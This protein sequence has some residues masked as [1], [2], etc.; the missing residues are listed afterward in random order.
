MK[1]VPEAATA[2]FVGT[3][4]DSLTGRGGKDGTPLRQTPWGEIAFQLGGAEAFAVVAEHDAE[5]IAPAGDVI[6]QFLPKDR[7]AL[8]LMDE[9]H[10]L[11]E[12]EPEDRP[13]DAALQLPPEPLGG[14][15]RR[16]TTW[17]WPCRSRRVAD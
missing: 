1:A 11:R 14:G 15:A 17:C 12:P 2:V 7:P 3:E 4:F 8:I 13:D 5:R 10:Q 6:R 16:R 9:L